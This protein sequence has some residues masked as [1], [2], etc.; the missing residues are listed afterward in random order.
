MRHYT[1]NVA[2]LSTDVMNAHKGKNNEVDHDHGI[3]SLT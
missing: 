1:L 2:K 3:I